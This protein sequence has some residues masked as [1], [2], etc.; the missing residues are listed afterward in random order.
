MPLNPAPSPAPSKRPYAF[1]LTTLSW[2]PT[3]GWSCE[4]IWLGRKNG[5]TRLSYGVVRFWWP[6]REA[7]CHD[8][9]LDWATLRTHCD[10]RHGGTPWFIAGTDGS[11]WSSPAA[12]A[13]TLPLDEQRQMRSKLLNMLNQ[14]PLVP[15][16]FDGWYRLV[17][18][19]K[20]VR[21]A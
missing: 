18:A 17:S 4:A 9:G 2:D 6:F 16:D 20:E 19:T 1:D 21:H 5:V 8:A 11:F 15:A 7:D 3:Y 13:P 10:E 12:G 14:L